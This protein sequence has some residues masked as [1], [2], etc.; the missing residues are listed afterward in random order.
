MSEARFRSR[1]A[2]RSLFAAHRDGRSTGTDEVA[3]QIGLAPRAI[4]RA[5][6]H[7][8]SEG[9]LLETLVPE[10]A[11]PPATMALAGALDAVEARLRIACGHRPDST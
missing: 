8:A 10:P 7:A 11:D 4:E 2:L 1:A 5:V 9:A 6:R 3:A